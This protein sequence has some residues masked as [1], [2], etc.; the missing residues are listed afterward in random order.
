VS[1]AYVSTLLTGWLVRD[2]VLTWEEYRGLMDNLLAAEGPA[3]GE[4]RLSEWLA[5]NV[6]RVG[7]EYASEVA[8]HYAGVKN[9][10]TEDTEEHRESGGAL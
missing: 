6:D 7:Q 9:S 5:E 3:A 4:T 1:A 10:T 2:V 8:R